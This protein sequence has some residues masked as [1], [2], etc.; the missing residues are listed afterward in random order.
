MGVYWVRIYPRGVSG[1]SL[2]PAGWIVGVWG[3]KWTEGKS[4]L[5]V[6]RRPHARSLPRA[7]H[8]PPRE[9][10]TTQGG[11]LAKFSRTR[12]W[13]RRHLEAGTPRWMQLVPGGVNGVYLETWS[14]PR[15][16]ERRTRRAC[17]QSS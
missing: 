10:P 15:T 11:A 3:H 8:R 7:C 6:L 4:A 16:R 5:E 14:P 1:G 17:R 13:R 12:A 2:T 9:L